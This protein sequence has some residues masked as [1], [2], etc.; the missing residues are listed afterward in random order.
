[1]GRGELQRTVKRV[2]EER[3]QDS[4][5]TRSIRNREKT[6]LISG[7]CAWISIAFFKVGLG[8]RVFL[9]GVEHTSNIPED[10]SVA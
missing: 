6:A 1:V 5:A 8:W 9:S 2:F 4:S 7:F 10:G 3:F